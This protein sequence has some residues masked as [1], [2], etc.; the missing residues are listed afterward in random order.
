MRKK[1]KILACRE[2]TKTCEIVFYQRKK[3][4]KEKLISIVSRE[5][6]GQNN[7]EQK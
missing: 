4:R 1:R 3:E 2:N 6:A 7:D 5:T